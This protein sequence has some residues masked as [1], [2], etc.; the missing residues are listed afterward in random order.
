MKTWLK[1]AVAALVT[2]AVAILLVGTVSAQTVNPE[3]A[4]AAD[5]F[6]DY[7]K[8][9][10]DAATAAEAPRTA[11]RPGIG[12][13]AQPNEQAAAEKSRLEEVARLRLL[14]V[15]AVETK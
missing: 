12:Y 4:A 9:Y 11:Y 1:I 2:L 7:C 13:A 3:P 14:Q 6:C 8:D 5:P 10:T 15:P